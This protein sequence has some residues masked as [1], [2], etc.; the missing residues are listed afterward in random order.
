MVDLIGNDQ[1]HGKSIGGMDPNCC[2]YEHV[3]GM[4]RSC[5]SECGGWDLHC[6]SGSSEWAKAGPKQVDLDAAMCHVS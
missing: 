2:A 5:T 1:I 3:I 4:N 6:F